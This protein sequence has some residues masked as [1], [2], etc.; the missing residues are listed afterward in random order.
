MLGRAV[1][2]GLTVEFR[3]LLGERPDTA[4][5]CVGLL[6]PRE[7]SR[8]CLPLKGRALVEK[9]FILVLMKTVCYL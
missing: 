9:V 3:K 4:L 5:G 2:D 8:F 1:S 6:V 7:R